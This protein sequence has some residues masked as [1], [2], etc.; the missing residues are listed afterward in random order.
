MLELLIA[1]GG[2]LLVGWFL[3]P[4]PKWVNDMWAKLFG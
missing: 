3:L 1:F 2:G 4:A